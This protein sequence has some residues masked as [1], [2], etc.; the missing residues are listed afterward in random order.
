MSQTVEHEAARN[1]M[2]Q[3]ARKAQWQ[4]C[5]SIENSYKTIIPHLKEHHP[6]PPIPWIINTGISLNSLLISS[7]SLTPIFNTL[8]SLQHFSCLC[9]WI[10]HHLLPEHLSS[11]LIFSFSD[12]ILQIKPKVIY[13]KYKSN[14]I[15]LA[16]SSSGYQILCHEILLFLI[17]CFITKLQ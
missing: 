13:L 15:S 7:W 1:S 8:I 3:K 10:Q 4:A 17:S 16:K 9:I 6:Y 14:H 11:P 5:K 12:S 2:K